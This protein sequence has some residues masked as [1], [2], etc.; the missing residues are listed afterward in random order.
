MRAEFL[1]YIANDNTQTCAKDSSERIDKLTKIE[2]AH[3]IRTRRM[4][5]NKKEA[6]RLN[7]PMTVTIIKLSNT[8]CDGCPK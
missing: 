1:I 2:R 7:H 4:N 6:N 8:K 3:F 5:G